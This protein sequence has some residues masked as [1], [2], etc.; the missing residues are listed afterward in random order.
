MLTE[1]EQLR[2]SERIVAWGGAS[3]GTPG[4]LQEETFSAEG[5]TEAS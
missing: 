1:H 2:R 3:S 4:I 5:P